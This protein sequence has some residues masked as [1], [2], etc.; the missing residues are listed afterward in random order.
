MSNGPLIV[1]GIAAGLIF[2]GTLGV[3]IASA[4][5]TETQTCTVESKDRSATKDGGSDMRIYTRDCGVLQV[6]DSLLDVRFDSAD[7]YAS[8]QE[9]KRYEFNTRGWRLP[10]LSMFPNIIQAKEVAP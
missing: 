6:A 3:G 2:A 1:G 8:L 7:M 4:A 10:A 5:H 9:G